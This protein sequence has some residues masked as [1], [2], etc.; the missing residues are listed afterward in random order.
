MNLV[1]EE[2][3]RGRGERKGREEGEGGGGKGA[4]GFCLGFV[5]QV[6]V[7]AASKLLGRGA[8]RRGGH[9]GAPD[10]HGERE[11]GTSCEEW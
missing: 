8:D 4:H 1:R 2:G 7:P 9:E 11:A 6:H 3:E 10:G 5:W